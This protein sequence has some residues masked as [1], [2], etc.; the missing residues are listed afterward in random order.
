M[1]R[2]Q[3]HATQLCCHE[4]IAQLPPGIVGILVGVRLVVQ[5]NEGGGTSFDRAWRVRTAALLVVACRHVGLCTLWSL[6]AIHGTA[7]EIPPPR[8]Q[9]SRTGAE[10]REPNRTELVRTYKQHI[11]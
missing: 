4:G 2:N 11:N 1:Q 3:A 8:A 7:R 10:L 9:K 6:G 5:L